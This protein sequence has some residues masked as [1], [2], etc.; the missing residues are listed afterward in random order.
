M[1]TPDDLTKIA[2]NEPEPTP[3]QEHSPVRKAVDTV[4]DAGKAV[5]G[6]GISAVDNIKSLDARAPI[7]TIQ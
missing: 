7:T 5:V 1:L 2:M 4:T 3:V 6:A